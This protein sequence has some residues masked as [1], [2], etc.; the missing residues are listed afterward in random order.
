MRFPLPT[1]ITALLFPQASF[2]KMIR[3]GLRALF[4]LALFRPSHGQNCPILGSAYPPVADSSSSPA[5][6]AAKVSFRD[7]LTEL[8]ASGQIGNSTAFSLQVFGRDDSGDDPIFEYYHTGLATS[9]AG[10]GSISEIRS[11]NAT[12][13]PRTLYRIGSISK[14]ISVYAILAKLG[15]GYWNEPVTKY[16]S[17][18]ADAADQGESDA[19]DHVQWS[20]VTLGALASHM[21][22]IGR[23]CMSCCFSPLFP[24]LISSFGILHGDMCT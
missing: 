23:D 8:L 19:V 20:E 3:T 16:V 14:L 7:A 24:T 22:G 5:L 4:L 17:E 10:N 21:S 6:N 13:G 15:G 9:S 11:R 18:L 2:S 1:P 12:V